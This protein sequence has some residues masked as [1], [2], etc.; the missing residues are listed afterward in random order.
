M[1]N[2]STR[3]VQFDDLSSSRM[4]SLYLLGARR[5]REVLSVCTFLARC[6]HSLFLK[7]K[8]RWP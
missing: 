8:K 4:S 6:V 3:S 7:E 1:E 2:C 5:L